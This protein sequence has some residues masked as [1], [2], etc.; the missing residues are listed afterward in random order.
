MYY[1]SSALDNDTIFVRTAMQR[2]NLK[3]KIRSSTVRLKE[4]AVRDRSSASARKRHQ[5]G[6]VVRSPITLDTAYGAQALERLS[7]LIL[8]PSNILV[9]HPCLSVGLTGLTKS[10][11]TADV[12]Y[13]FT[14]FCS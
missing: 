12:R 8:P 7:P 2:L 11:G 13:N 1:N 6:G 9:F 4:R 14:R 10:D 3:K 5:C